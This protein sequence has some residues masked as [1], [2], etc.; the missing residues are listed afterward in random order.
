MSLPDTVPTPAQVSGP[1]LNG[2]VF[3][4]H[5]PIVGAHVYLLQPGTTGYGSAATSLLGNNGATSANG[6]VLTANVSDPNVPTTT[7]VPEYVTSDANGQFSLTGA[8]TCTAG[9]PV[10][11][12]AYGGF[13]AAFTTTTTTTTTVNVP[14]PTAFSDTITSINVSAIQ[15][16]TG[17]GNE[18]TATYNIT[19]TPQNPSATLASPIKIQGLADQDFGDF[20]ILNSTTP[21]AATGLTATTFTITAPDPNEEIGTG[22]YGQN[23]TNFGFTPGFGTKGLAS[24]TQTVEVPTPVTTTTTTTTPAGSPNGAIVQLA[25][26]GNCPTTGNLNFAS[27]S[28]D[29]I[30]FVYMNE[31]ST[32]AT[33]YTFQP[34]TLATKNSAWDIGSSGTPQ[35][36]I[37]IENAAA[38]AAQLY[39]IQGATNISTSNDGEGHLANFQ[40]QLFT[41][42]E[43]TGLITAQPNQGNGIV[44]EYTIDTL[45]NILAA[46]VD[47]TSS[48]AGA[49][50]TLFSNATDNGL[51]G[52]TQPTD[53]ATAAINI[54][55]Y[56]AGNHS[57]TSGV[58]PAFV[59]NIFGIPTGAVPYVP[60]LANAPNDFTIAISYP[61]ASPSTS[62]YDAANTTLG[63]AESIA[64]DFFGDPWITAQTDFDIVSWSPLGSQLEEHSSSQNTTGPKSYI[65]GYVSID[66]SGNAWTGSANATTGIQE[67][68]NNE[69]LINTFPAT[70]GGYD[71]AYTVVT[72]KSGDAFFFASDTGTTPTPGQGATFNTQGNFEMWEY[73]SSGVLQSSSTSCD[74]VTGPFVYDCT[75]QSTG[76]GR[77]TVFNTGDNVAHGA[78][79]DASATTAAPLAAGHLWL[80]SEGS[81]Y[82][83]AR[84]SP[85]GVADF[86][87]T[88]NTQQP[89]FPSIDA[90]GNAWIASQATAS[91]IYEITPTTTT[92]FFTVKT[93]DSG[94]GTA[95]G[96]AEL[97]STFGSAVD[98]NGNVWFANRAGNGGA[99]GN[100]PG[101][102]TLLV[103]NGTNGLAISPPQN[104]VPEAQYPNSGGGTAF[105][106]VL[107]GSLNVAID[108]S[109]NVWITNYTGGSITV[110]IGAA[111]PVVTPLSLAAGDNVLGTKP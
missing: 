38:N 36:L 51:T 33:A 42:N 44:P 62:G 18:D 21:Y 53:T 37:G 109:G 19:V 6:Y 26:L 102:N 83:I 67:F 71:S 56:P 11:L 63:L 103:L 48:S 30:N 68:N 7:P 90:N 61:T 13:T 74:G 1:A 22:T 107:D 8:Y 29:P 85:A 84:V 9:S 72:D 60:D 55:R 34:F 2:S 57:S 54:A 79:E 28:S 31:V 66:G 104:Y 77:T 41:T 69:V 100:T 106:P 20:A 89:E 35:A 23:N 47:S 45:A 12:Y 94:N 92:P 59:S 87:F 76:G 52:G 93:I 15:R 40:T 75:S 105:T 32:I 46:C 4:G 65:Y 39:D 10:Y 95:S 58:N 5:A 108:P 3:G 64:F 101:E 82:Q 78:I 97:T 73:N 70:G 14:T 27:G 25:T 50:P 43:R 81:P 24:G 49:C 80:T 17:H 111:A 98:G 99:I 16:V 86:V 88:T 110:I 91:V 96:T